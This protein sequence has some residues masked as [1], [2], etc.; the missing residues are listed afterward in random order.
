MLTEFESL[1]QR[2]I[3]LDPASIGT[4]AIARAVQVR[5]AA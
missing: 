1:L 4:A 3:G 2:K 5:L